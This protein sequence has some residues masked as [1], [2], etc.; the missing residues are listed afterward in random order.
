MPDAHFSP[1]I[2]KPT[3]SHKA[4][5]SATSDS[6]CGLNACCTPAEQADAP[7]NTVAEAKR[8]SGRN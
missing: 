4:D 7:I 1:E 6:C 2:I 3:T 8:A 5:E